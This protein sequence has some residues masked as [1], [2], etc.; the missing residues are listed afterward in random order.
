[1]LHRLLTL[2]TL[3]EDQLIR[4]GRVNF[5][6]ANFA[7]VF[8]AL[9]AGISY[10]M[11]NVR[12]ATEVTWQADTLLHDARILS[13]DLPKEKP[14]LLSC[15]MVAKTLNGSMDILRT[16]PIVLAGMI[17]TFLILGFLNLR[18]RKL[19][20]ELQHLKKDNHPIQPES[21]NKNQKTYE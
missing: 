19:G 12:L 18:L 21:S 4:W 9:C 11:V 1:M 14:L 20:L 3:R 6:I 17:P 2:L 5:W 15:R 13:M 16:V 8:F 7:A 10:Y